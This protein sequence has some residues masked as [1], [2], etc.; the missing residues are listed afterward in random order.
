[1]S[2]RNGASGPEEAEASGPAAADK[3]K[4]GK[5][6]IVAADDNPLTLA[7]LKALIHAA[8]DL[9][10]VGEAADGV[11]ALQLIE[12]SAPDIAAIDVPMPGLGVAELG[13]YLAEP[14]PKAKILA[15]TALQDSACL[16]ELLQAGAQGYLLKRSAPA[17]LVGA[18]RA[19]LS[20]TIYIDPAIASRLLIRASAGETEPATPLSQRELT[21]LKLVA[22]G[23][24]SKE[25]AAEL[26]LSIKTVQTYKA[27]AK[28]K[29]RLQTRSDI[30]RYG[31][32]R[33]WIDDM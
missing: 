32:A 18:I 19:V 29:L 21:V 2:E 6:R 23:F 8:P 4:S 30:V 28:K 13:R 31:A 9:E 22:R 3:M 1:M 27:R 24:G 7:G 5:I 10:L 33:G 11:S 17:E 26:K 16:L 15:L 20:G 14:R 25:M 12:N